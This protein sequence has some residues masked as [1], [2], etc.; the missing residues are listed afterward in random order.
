MHLRKMAKLLYEEGLIQKFQFDVESGK[1]RV[2]VD[3]EKRM[4][5]GKQGR[6]SFWKV[7]DEEGCLSLAN[8][9]VR[10]RYLAYKKK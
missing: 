1:L 4:Q 10:E 8:A 7:V 6:L 3:G 9:K 5:N 2:K